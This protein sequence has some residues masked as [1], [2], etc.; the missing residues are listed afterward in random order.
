[1]ACGLAALT[2]LSAACGGH[3]GDGA[4]S[5]SSN[6]SGNGASTTDQQLKFAQCMRKNGVDMPDPKPGQGSGA[7]TIGGNGASPE[8]IEK[9]M[10]I[11]RNVAGIPAPK[12]LSPEQQDK[13]I[14]FTACMRKHGIDMP[15]P[16]FGGGARKAI[17]VPTGSG[18][19]KFD[20]ANRA[21]AQFQ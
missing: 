15:D 6:T 9:A 12:P 10:K 11:C 5:N 20:K 18:R 17:P 4:S 19:E 21:C 14:K 7:L 13:L 16:D 3:S 8:K 1:V 2:F